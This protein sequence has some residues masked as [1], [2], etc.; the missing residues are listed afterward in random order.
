MSF[1]ATLEEYV[2]LPIVLRIIG[3][4]L[5]LLGFFVGWGQMHAGVKI[6]LV[7]GVIIFTVGLKYKTIYS[8]TP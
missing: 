2:N 4:I 1:L 3:L 7:F 8:K 5:F 6:L